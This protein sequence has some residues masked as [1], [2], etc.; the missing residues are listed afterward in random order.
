MS[1]V[2]QSNVQWVLCWGRAFCPAGNILVLAIP[3][4]KLRTRNAVCHAPAPALSPTTRWFREQ[5]RITF[6]AVCVAQ[7]VQAPRRGSLTLPKQL[8]DAFPSN[9]P[10]GCRPV[11]WTRGPLFQEIACKYWRLQV[12]ISARPR[13]IAAF[14]TDSYTDMKNFLELCTFE[15]RLPSAA[16]IL[17]H[18]LEQP[19]HVATNSHPQCHCVGETPLT[20]SWGVHSVQPSLSSLC[21]SWGVD[22]VQPSLCCSSMVDINYF[23]R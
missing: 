6:Q 17:L 11:R 2:T 22:S 23:N 5:D 8:L 15:T 19:I 21:C 7:V 13:Q 10:R 14:K 4:Q 1:G 12:V 18:Y 20:K 16:R 3:E 9:L